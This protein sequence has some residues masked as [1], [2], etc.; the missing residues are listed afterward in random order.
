MSNL[1]EYYNSLKNQTNNQLGLYLFCCS[2]GVIWTV[3]VLFFNAR[4]V[5][6][7]ATFL[8]NLYLK[9]YSKNVWIKISKPFNL[10]FLNFRVHLFNLFLNFEKDHFPFPSYRAR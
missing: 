10:H 5:G 1:D 6:S 2:I 3:Y 8:V 4:L 9:R 7:I